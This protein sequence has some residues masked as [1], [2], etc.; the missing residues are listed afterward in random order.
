M[1]YV[2]VHMTGRQA[3]VQQHYWKDLC[4]PVFLGKITVL[5]SRLAAV[6]W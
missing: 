3:Q 6:C 4:M 1:M 2:Y 5:N